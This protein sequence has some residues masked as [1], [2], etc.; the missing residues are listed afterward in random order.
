M[1]AP[2]RPT[3]L[4]VAVIGAGSYGTCLAILAASAG[5]RV[6]LWCRGE[7]AAAELAASRANQAYLPGFPLPPSIDVSADL[8]RVVRGKAIVV[9]VTPSHAIRDVLGRAA[10]WLDP[11]V[12]VVNASKG[13]EDGTL[14]TIDRVY[15]D[16]FPARVAAR[17]TFL[18]GPTFA[19]EIAGGMPSAIV[20]AGR[21]PETTA[22]VQRALSTDRF[23]TY[24]TDDVIGVLVGGAIKNV[25]AI[26]A[27]VSDGLGFGSNARAALITRGLAEITRVGVAMGADPVT[28]AGL[29]G[30]GD[31]VLTCSSDTSRNRKVGLAL[32]R[33]QTMADI[34]AE[35]RMVAEGVKTTKV[36]WELARKL[37]VPAPITDVMYAIVHEGVPAR[38]AMMKLMQRS[39]RSERD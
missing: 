38:D 15:A 39:L 26:A 31:L 9:G 28:F 37:A 12:V 11:D 24:S 5:H 36:A 30:M 2:D 8:E 10:A 34:L 4:D 20:L 7:A 23:R 14:Q 27:G 3:S 25:V 29:S 22:L 35:M 19:A 6:A 17:A 16:I 32:G 33:G 21:D 13:L 1:P 18:S